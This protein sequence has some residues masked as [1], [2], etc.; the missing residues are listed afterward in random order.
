MYVRIKPMTNYLVLKQSFKNQQNLRLHSM[1]LYGVSTGRA[2]LSPLRRPASLDFSRACLAPLAVDLIIPLKLLLCCA[3]L[4][5][6]KG[7]VSNTQV[8]HQQSRLRSL[9]TVG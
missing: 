6:E 2:F 5:L 3:R 1:F 8:T 7:A 9:L 4:L